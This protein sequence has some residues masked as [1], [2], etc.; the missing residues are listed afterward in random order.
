MFEL[1]GLGKE[2]GSLARSLLGRNIFH[3]RFLSQDK[4]SLKSVWPIKCYQES[5]TNIS[6]WRFWEK[7][8]FDWIPVGI[9]LASLMLRGMKDM[10]QWIF[11]MLEFFYLNICFCVSHPKSVSRI[12]CRIL[13]MG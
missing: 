9:Y 12:I 4:E 10:D 6:K 3:I 1:Q 5:K 11:L 13:V 7:L 8:I 2:K